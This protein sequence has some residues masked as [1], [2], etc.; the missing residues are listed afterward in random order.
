VL[1]A[2]ADRHRILGSPGRG[3]WSTARGCSDWSCRYTLNLEKHFFEIAGF[4]RRGGRDVP[5]LAI[6]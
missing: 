5:S 2:E 6:E 1:K 3:S 4:M